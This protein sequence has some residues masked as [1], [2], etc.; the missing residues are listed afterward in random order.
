MSKLI[1][2]LKGHKCKITFSDVT[3]FLE[4]DKKVYEI[5]DVDDEWV[6]VA[7]I[8]KKA[9]EKKVIVRIEVIDRI[10]LVD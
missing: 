7:F 4:D 6:K 3:S 10:E 5:I 9:V 8:D 2:E 1:N